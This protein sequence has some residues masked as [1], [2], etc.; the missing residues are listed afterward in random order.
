VDATAPVARVT[1]PARKKRARRSAW[2]TLRGKV[3]D[4][5]PSSGIKRVQ[6]SA[7][8][9]S[10]ARCR[11]L[12]RKG[13]TATPCTARTRWVTA[14]LKGKGWQLKLKGLRL[15]AVRFRARALDNAGNLQKPPFSLKIR[16]KR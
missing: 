3:S 12:G 7:V 16:L 5:K 15:G 10:G 2:R 6:V 9:R 4:A 14:K 11:S 13:F 8:S 1:P